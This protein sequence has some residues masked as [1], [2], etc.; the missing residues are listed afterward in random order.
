[1]RS[2]DILGRFR[3]FSVSSLIGRFFKVG[4]VIRLRTP[5]KVI[6]FLYLL[7]SP[8][9]QQIRSLIV[10]QII[11]MVDNK[12]IIYKSHPTGI[13]VKG[14]HLVL[15]TR[16]FDLNAAPPSGGVITKNIYVSYDPYLRSKL[17]DSSITSYTPAFSLGQPIF[18]H[19]IARVLKSD[20]SDF[21]QGE[22]VRGLLNFEQYSALSKE[23]IKARNL[24]KVNN[25]LGLDLKVYLGAMGM[26]GINFE[27]LLGENRN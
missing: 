10:E 16:Q 20:S 26:P 4:F 17:R 24:E 8:L 2:P 3:A 9:K 15:E 19:A 13:P 14:E 23:E 27:G 22:I 12:V 6:H 11:K 7:S 25:K 5:S 18:N 21:K 1:M